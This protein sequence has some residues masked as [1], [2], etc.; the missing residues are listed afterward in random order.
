[1]YIFAWSICSLI[2]SKSGF[3]AM[4]F[5]IFVAEI[6]SIQIDFMSAEQRVSQHIP[7]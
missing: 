2:R 7:G 6:D 5:F 4:F 1:M 3:L